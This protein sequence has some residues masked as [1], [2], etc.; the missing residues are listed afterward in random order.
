M[1]KVTDG[2][3]MEKLTDGIRMENLVI[4]KILHKPI[5]DETVRFYCEYSKM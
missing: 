5:S 1:G 3:R 4:G 2:I